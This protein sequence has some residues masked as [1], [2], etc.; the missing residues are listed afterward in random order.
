MKNRLFTVVLGFWSVCALSA[1]NTED[2]ETERVT[3]GL[4]ITGYRGTAMNV[5][6]PPKINGRPVTVIGESAFYEKGLT[7][8]TIP[9]S[10]TFIGYMAFAFNQLS[11]VHIPNSV[12]T[13]GGNAFSNNRLMS[14]SIPVDVT[15]GRKAFADN[16]LASITIGANIRL[17]V[18]SFDSDFVV[19]YNAHNQ[20]AGSYTYRNSRW[21]ISNSPR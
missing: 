16:Q 9:D 13:I 2:F 19:Y 12:T 1:Q 8:V 3:G 21:R 17:T 20:R 14:V 10:V 4:I 7:S 5:I 11:I 18:D 6:I 15:I